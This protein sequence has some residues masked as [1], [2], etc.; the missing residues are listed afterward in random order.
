MLGFCNHAPL[1]YYE[2]LSLSLDMDI[3]EE[4]SP[5]LIRKQASISEALPEILRKE[6]CGR[7]SCEQPHRAYLLR[8]IYLPEKMI[9]PYLKLKC[10]ELL[11]FLEMTEPAETCSLDP[12]HSGQTEIIR[13]IHDRITEDL[14]RVIP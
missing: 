11:L 10:Q 13:R 6:K 4:H 7:P 3:L 1:G 12:Y 9:L 8:S 5:E 2:G 14:R